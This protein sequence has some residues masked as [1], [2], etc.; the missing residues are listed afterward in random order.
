MEISLTPEL[1]KYIQS[2]VGTKK[3]QTANDVVCDVI[4]TAAQQDQDRQAQLEEFRR[5][6]QI[7]RDQYDRGEYIEIYDDKDEQAL[8]DRIERNGLAKLEAWRRGQA[9]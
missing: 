7:S 9:G 1:E 4:R 2:K 6:L 5:S 8:F 3:Y